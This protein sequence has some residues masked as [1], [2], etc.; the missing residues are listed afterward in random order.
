MNPTWG[1]VLAVIIHIKGSKQPILDFFF[2]FCLKKEKKHVKKEEPFENTEKSIFDSFLV[3]NT[4][5]LVRVHNKMF[6]YA[7]KEQIQ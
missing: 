2:L 4:L 1:M 7:K 3:R 5:K 6:F